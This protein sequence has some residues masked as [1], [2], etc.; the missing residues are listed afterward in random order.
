M[1]VTT[2][3]EQLRV[4][5]YYLLLVITTCYVIGRGY[6]KKNRYC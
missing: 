5:F 4:L 2:N 6:I 3:E 1:Q